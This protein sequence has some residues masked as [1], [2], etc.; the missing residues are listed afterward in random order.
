MNNTQALIEHME[1]ILRK[2]T[3]SAEDKVLWVSRT[4]E[5]PFEDIAFLIDIFENNEEL[6]VS[7][8]TNLKKKIGAGNDLDK[9]KKV[10]E[11]ER[12]EIM[13]SIIKTL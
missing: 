9:I 12:Q 8:T 2:S 13:D 7:A 6:L 3:L 1:V 11:E 5:L 10:V 4:N